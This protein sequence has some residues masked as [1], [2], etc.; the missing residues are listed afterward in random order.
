MEQQ[1][2]TVSSQQDQVLTAVGAE[3]QA[4]LLHLK[5]N[6]TGE[7]NLRR[8]QATQRVFLLMGRGRQESPAQ[9]ADPGV[10]I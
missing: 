4:S 8:A 10:G 5:K 1:G 2:P 9:R 3:Q 7:E 6:A